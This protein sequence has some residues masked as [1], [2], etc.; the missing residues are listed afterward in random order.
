[1]KSV[2][3][4]PWRWLKATLA[5]TAV[6]ALLLVVATGS[7]STPG[8]TGQ[9]DQSLPD[10]VGGATV[11]GILRLVYLTILAVA[12]YRWLLSRDEVKRGKGPQRR[13]S[14]A[15]T[16]LVILAVGGALVLGAA[17]RDTSVTN[18]VFPQAEEE[19]PLPEVLDD[20]EIVDESPPGSFPEFMSEPGATS[21]PVETLLSHPWL[22]A[23]TLLMVA[24]VALAILIRRPADE[25]EPEMEVVERGRPSVTEAIPAPV[26]GTDPRSRV[27]AAYRA[28]ERA[29][30]GL[31]RSRQP[32]ETVAGHLRRLGGA[33]ARKLAHIYD[34][35]R[36]SSHD[37]TGDAAD[38][39]ERASRVVVEVSG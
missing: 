14:P 24:G 20:G 9:V 27:F 19:E 22:A 21:S 23:L 35:A 37:V 29:A 8:G 11:G 26:G 30:R 13:A 34:L 36:F 16:L 18:P 28:V 32:S 17:L 2:L 7:L 5:A 39:A 25:A 31:G 38:E 33:D 15:V 3:D 12:L 6:V 10:I 4:T 1:M